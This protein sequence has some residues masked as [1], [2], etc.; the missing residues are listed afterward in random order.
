[1]IVVVII[2][3]RWWMGVGMMVRATREHHHKDATYQNCSD[4]FKSSHAFV[5]LESWMLPR[6]SERAFLRTNFDVP[7]KA[8]G[9][10]CLRP[11]RGP[12]LGGFTLIAIGPLGIS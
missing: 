11:K 12:I 3:R 2:A 8:P 9:T 7:G 5:L 6:M 1:M 10:G 4:S